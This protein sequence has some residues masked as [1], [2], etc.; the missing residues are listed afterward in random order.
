MHGFTLVELLL[1]ASLA[2]VVLTAAWSWLWTVAASAHRSGEAA[3]VT[4]SLAFARRQLLRDAHL[5]VGLAAPVAGADCGAHALA[6]H[7]PGTPTAPE[8][9]QYAVN[10]SRQTLWRKTSSS[11]VAEGV[12]RFDVAYLDAEGDEVSPGSDGRLSAAAIALVR[13]V[14]VSVE[15][16]SGSTAGAATWTIGLP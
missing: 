7:L 1:A 11:Y 16:A 13:V 4:S 10:A 2:G 5:A 9:V 3:E 14:R 6:L 12:T 8:I 15:I